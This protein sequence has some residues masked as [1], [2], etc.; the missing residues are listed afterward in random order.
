MQADANRNRTIDSLRAIAAL[1]VFI[2][3]LAKLT[4]LAQRRVSAIG[5]MLF[6][7]ISGYCIVLSLGKSELNSVKKFL[8]R[9]AFRLYP[10]YWLAVLF[11]AVV[12]KSS[13]D[14]LLYNLTMFQ[15][16]FGVHNINHVFWTL[17]IELI[18]YGLITLLLLAGMAYKPMIYAW[19]I[20]I[21]I[22]ATYLAVVLRILIGVQAPFG[23]MMLL[24]LFFLGGMACKKNDRIYQLIIL[25]CSAAAFY[26][27]IYLFT[28]HVG[29]EMAQQ[30]YFNYFNYSCVLL[31][32]FLS[33]NLN[34]FSWSW[35]SYIGKISYCIYLFHVPIKVIIEQHIGNQFIAF[36][37]VLFLTLIFSTLVHHFFEV[38][39]INLGRWVGNKSR[40]KYVLA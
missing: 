14:E 35:L 22:A 29:W 19:V 5:V 17:F 26:G 7:L 27:L 33:I 24:S 25:A 40:K 23:Y 1:L 32:F 12:W 36:I 20:A 18:F 31:L 30:S 38:P 4:D 16:I 6:F 13:L 15:T 8:I 9:R 2:A 37:C 10:V 39:F 21:L 28:K 3:H 11:A 34:W